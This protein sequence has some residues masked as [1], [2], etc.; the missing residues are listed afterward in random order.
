MNR[1]TFAFECRVKASTSKWEQ[2]FCTVSSQDLAPLLENAL[3]ADGL[4]ND[5]GGDRE[6]FKVVDSYTETI[7]TNHTTYLCLWIGNT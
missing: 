3:Y 1:K 7:D 5:L 6:G 2:F 4:S